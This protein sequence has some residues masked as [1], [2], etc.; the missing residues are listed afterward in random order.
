MSS[1]TFIFLIYISSISIEVVESPI[2]NHQVTLRRTE[3]VADFFMVVTVGPSLVRIV[4]RTDNDP[5]RQIKML[6]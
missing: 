6:P 5:G 4:D 1:E 2:M 3:R